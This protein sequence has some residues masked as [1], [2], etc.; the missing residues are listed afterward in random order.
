M[1][2][3]NKEDSCLSHGGKDYGFGEELPASLGKD[4]IKALV[5]SGAAVEKFAA[6]LKTDEKDEIIAVQSAKIRELE[7]KVV[8]GADTDAQATI[9]GLNQTI[10]ELQQQIEAQNATIAALTAPQGEGQQS[11]GPASENAAGPGAKE[12]GGKNK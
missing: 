8:S 2:Y 11:A 9:D 3:W 6:P 10:T 4:R 5:D 7:E 12:K 1:A